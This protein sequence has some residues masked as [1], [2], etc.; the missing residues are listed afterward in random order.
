MIERIPSDQLPFMKRVLKLLGRDVST[1]NLANATRKKSREAIEAE[2]NLEGNQNPT[3]FLK[4]KHTTLMA[5][6]VPM[7]GGKLMADALIEAQATVLADP[8]MKDEWA[9]AQAA[10]GFNVVYA[11]SDRY[12]EIIENGTGLTNAEV[13][14]ALV[15]AQLQDLFMKN[16]PSKNRG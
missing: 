6:K 11:R 7:E 12:W 16:H 10:S 4:A 1:E 2:K 14:R 15:P 8:E 13:L 3:E 9:K 5:L